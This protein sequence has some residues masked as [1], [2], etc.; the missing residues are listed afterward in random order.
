MGMGS[1]WGIGNRE[2]GIG[3]RESE[4][5]PGARA[6]IQLPGRLGR[7]VRCDCLHAHVRCVFFSHAA[8]LLRDARTVRMHA[9]FYALQQVLPIRGSAPA[10]RRRR[11]AFAPA[12]TSGQR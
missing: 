11:S 8:L 5:H 2:S 10:R 12:A 9:L 4:E 3:N 6:M 7:S 1:S